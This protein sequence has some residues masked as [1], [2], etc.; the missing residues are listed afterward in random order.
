MAWIVPGISSFYV[1][2]PSSS[3]WSG[4]AISWYGVYG[5]PTICRW[6]EPIVSRV[7]GHNRWPMVP[8]VYYPNATPQNEGSLQKVTFLYL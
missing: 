4:G 8:G 1:G 5:S 2:G 7:L 3:A 6:R